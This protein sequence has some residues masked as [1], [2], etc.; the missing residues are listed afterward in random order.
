MNCWELRV[1]VECVVDSVSVLDCLLRSPLLG[2]YGVMFLTVRP[3][4]ISDFT[5]QYNRRG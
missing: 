1:Y 5:C 2:V 4:S 3:L